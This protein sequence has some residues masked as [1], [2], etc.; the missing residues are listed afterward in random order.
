MS[1]TSTARAA[2]N[3][4][5]PVNDPFYLGD[6]VY[7]RTEGHML[8]LS[9]LRGNGEHVIYLDETVWEDLKLYVE[10]R[11][12]PQMQTAEEPPIIHDQTTGCEPTSP[13][14]DAQ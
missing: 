3:E 2:K 5:L 10:L 7:V 6:G 1:I 12:R 13:T 4:R 14:S 8:R 11:N 9:T